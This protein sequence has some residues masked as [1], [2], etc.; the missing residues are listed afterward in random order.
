M[1]R[2]KRSRQGIAVAAILLT[3]FR[4]SEALIKCDSSL[5][6]KHGH[7]TPMLCSL[8]DNFNDNPQTILSNG[9]LLSEIIAASENSEK[10]SLES[11]F[12]AFATNKEFVHNIWQKKP[13]LC[14][15]PLKNIAGA[16]TMADVENAVNS[17]FLEAGRGT[18][19]D[20]S[21]W[22]MAAVSKVSFTRDSNFL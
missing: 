1:Q 19:K 7:P 15:E 12:A 14:N 20:G 18:F 21:G 17:D 16:Y 22:T 2:E 11:T 9:D 3:Y 6:W 8:N 13:Y 4:R 5:R 10:L